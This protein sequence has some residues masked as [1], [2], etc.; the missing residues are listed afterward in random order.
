LACRWRKFHIYVIDDGSSDNTAELVRE[1]FI[2]QRVHVV[3][4]P[5][6]GK[7][8]ALNEGLRQAHADIIVTLDG[9][10][11]FAPDAI[12]LLVRHFADPQVGAVAGSAAVGN[13]VNLITRFQALEYA[14][15]QNLDRRALEIVNGITVVPGS[16]SAWRRDAL[17]QIGGFSEDT[18]AED[19][20]ATIRLERAGWKVL[21]E[22]RAT[23]RTEAPETLRAFLRQ[24]LRWMFGTLQVAYKHRAAIWR[25]APLGVAAVGL[26]NIFVF[27]FLFTLLAPLI[28][29]VLLGAIVSAIH[30]YATG[31]NDGIP[32]N[33]VLVLLYWAYFQALEIAAAVL[34]VSIDWRRDVWGLMP[35]LLIQRFYYRQLLYYTAIRVAFAACKGRM[36]YWGKLARTGTVSAEAARALG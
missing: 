2:T 25:G 22:P 11:L 32:K 23:A 31:L 5:N 1:T 29:L 35:L 18:L 20:D 36:Q 9:D 15:N 26:P 34:A 28:D 21:Y 27:Q 13:R 4:K 8:S 10:T 6:E 16:I 3:R 14:L 19:A 12:Q 33:L 24:R 7:W 17:L 30:E